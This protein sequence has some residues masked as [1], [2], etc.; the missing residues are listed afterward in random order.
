MIRKVIR[1]QFK[2]NKKQVKLF[3]KKGKKKKEKR[4]FIKF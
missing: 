1:F 2:M 4:E 3:L